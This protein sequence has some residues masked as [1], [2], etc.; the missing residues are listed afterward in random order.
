MNIESENRTDSLW[1]E[2]DPTILGTPVAPLKTFFFYLPLTFKPR[3]EM[4]PCFEALFPAQTSPRSWKSLNFKLLRSHLF[5]ISLLV[6]FYPEKSFD[7]EYTGR[8]WIQRNG[9]AG[10][11]DVREEPRRYSRG[12]SCFTSRPSACSASYSRGCQ[13]PAL[14]SGPFPS[15]HHTDI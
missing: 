4:S 8:A 7:K 2:W 9:A 15:T 1:V 12:Y 13:L 5:S 10:V 14:S 11:R 3:W 6:K